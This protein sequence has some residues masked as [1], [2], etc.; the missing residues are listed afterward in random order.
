MCSLILQGEITVLT[1]LLKTLGYGLS[2]ALLL[3]STV[4]H[5]GPEPAYKTKK[6]PLALEESQVKQHN[7]MNSIGK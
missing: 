4:G 2:A 5:K 3:F 6:N 7:F 1:L